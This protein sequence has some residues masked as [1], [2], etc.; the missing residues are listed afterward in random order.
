MYTIK[1]VEE[2]Y[3]LPASTLRFYEKEGIIPK[4]SR[5]DGGR[6][7]YTEKELESLQLVIAL[8]DTGMLMGDIK[9]NVGM[10]KRGY[11]S[12]EQR[13]NMLLSHIE[14]VE[15]NLQQILFHLEKMNFLEADTLGN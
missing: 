3:G 14:D 9:L 11:I 5:D 6:R 1:Q 10:V 2:M 8:R 7:K 13:R 4:I 15:K 12:L